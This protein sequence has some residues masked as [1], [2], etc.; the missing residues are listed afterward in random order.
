MVKI[1]VAPEDDD[2]AEDFAESLVNS[3]PTALGKKMRGGKKATPRDEARKLVIAVKNH[4]PGV[5]RVVNSYGTELTLDAKGKLYD[6]VEDTPKLYIQC[7]CETCRFAGNAKYKGPPSKTYIVQA[8]KPFTTTFKPHFDKVHS[9]KAVAKSK[10]PSMNL[11]TLFVAA[12]NTKFV[13]FSKKHKVPSPGE[14]SPASKST[15]TMVEATG[16]EVQIY[17]N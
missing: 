4:F 8:Q 10:K 11:S 14:G 16:S 5:A 13:D 7:C 17:T 2:A 12:A 3:T 15:A 1:V 6:E 9:D